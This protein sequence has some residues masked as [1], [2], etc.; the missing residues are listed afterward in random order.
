MDSSCLFGGGG[1]LLSGFVIAGNT[2]NTDVCMI[3]GLLAETESQ[4][5]DRTSQHFKSGFRT[6]SVR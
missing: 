4:H 6:S 3:C 1:T 5:S 2:G